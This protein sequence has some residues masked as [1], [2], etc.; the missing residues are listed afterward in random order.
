[1]AHAALISPMWLN[2]CGRFPIISLLAGSTSPASSCASQ[3]V[4]SK[5]APSSPGRPSQ[6]RSA[7]RL[8]E[9]AGPLVPAALQDGRPDLAAGSGPAVHPVLG[10]E[11]ACQGDRAVQR[12]PAHQLGIGEVAGLAADFPDALVLYRHRLAA[13]VRNCWVTGSSSPSWS[14]SSWAAPSNSP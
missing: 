8:S 9:G 7:E 6:A 10:A 12:H 13:V 1:M 3:N 5:N 14:T 4:H 2:A 11:L